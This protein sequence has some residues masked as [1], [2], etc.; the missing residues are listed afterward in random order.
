MLVLDRAHFDHMTGGDRALQH[1]ILDLFLGQIAGWRAAISAGE[2]WRDA[3]HTLK[4]SAR[5]IGLAAL[6]AACEEAEQASDSAAA[7]A[8]VGAALTQALAALEQFAAEAAPRGV[9]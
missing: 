1:E 8:G 5:G 4:G 2:G 7:L 3:V 6:A 9:R